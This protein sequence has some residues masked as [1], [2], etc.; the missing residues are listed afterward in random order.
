MREE[1]RSSRCSLWWKDLKKVWVSEGWGSSFE[2][3]IS[4]KVGDGKDVLFWE[5]YWLGQD[6][7]KRVFLRLIS[8]CPIKYAKVAEIGSWSD[9][10]WVWHVA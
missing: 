1:E 9:G 7:L 3:E 4:W 5:D 6:A 10:V 2:D 8:L